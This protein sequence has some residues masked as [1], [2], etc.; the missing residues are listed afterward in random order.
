MSTTTQTNDTVE[1]KQQPATP[2]QPT[3]RERAKEAP[4]GEGIRLSEKAAGQIKEILTKDNYPDTMYLYVAVK[5]G[6]CS[7]FQYV[8]DLRD[9]AQAP[10]DE[11]DEVFLSHGIPIVCNFVSYEAGR[12]AGTLIDYHDG[13]MG[14]GFT[15]NNPNAKHTCGCGSSYSP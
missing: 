5:G 2:A 15:F 14:A 4:E 8:L 9:E 13:L 7:G 11:S 6:G 3:V 1:L 10:V 12:M